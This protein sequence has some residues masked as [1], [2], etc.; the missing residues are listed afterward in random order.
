MNR[1]DLQ[2]I[3]L[4]AVST[5][6]EFPTKDLIEYVDADLVAD[7]GVDSLKMMDIWVDIE[8]RLGIVLGDLAATQLSSIRSI[9]EHLEKTVA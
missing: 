8:A 6:T 2:N 3:V 5:A 4:N 7:L 9:T 1:T